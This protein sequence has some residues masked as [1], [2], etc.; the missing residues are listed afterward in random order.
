MVQVLV[1]VMVPP[2]QVAEQVP[3]TQSD[4]PPSTIG[5]GIFR[6]VKESVQRADF[7]V[8]GS[9]HMHT[10]LRLPLQVVAEMW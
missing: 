7:F 5:A 9:A 10:V 2:E 1:W 6:G 8:P 4:Q 3:F